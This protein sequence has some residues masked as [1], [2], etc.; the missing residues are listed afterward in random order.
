M[1]T[2]TSQVIGIKI[3]GF[4]K[5]RHSGESRNPEWSQLTENT[6]LQLLPE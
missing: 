3:D 6:E 2:G 4:E 1:C 5:S